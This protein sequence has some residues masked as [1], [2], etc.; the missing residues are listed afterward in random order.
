[1]TDPVT[2][3]K[4]PVRMILR[5]VEYSSAAYYGSLARRQE[6]KRGPKTNLNDADLLME[7]RK[8]MDA[9]PFH[10]TGYKKIHARIAREL[11][12]KGI[13]IGKNRIFRI[14]KENNMLNAKSGG[15]GSSRPHD[16]T[17]ITNAP[18]KMWGTDGKKFFTRQDG[19]CWLFDVIDHFNSE[20][21]GF[22][23]VKIGDRFEASRA[24]QNAVIYR[25]GRLDEGICENLDVRSDRGS[26]YIS[27]YYRQTASRLGI[28]LS[29]TWARSP[30]SNGIAERFHRTIEEQ[31]FKIR[32]FE[33]I[34][35]AE[36]AIREFIE[37]YN[38]EWM[39][40]RLDY[41]S[42]REALNAYYSDKQKS[43]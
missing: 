14:M 30:E 22:N 23:V 12:N 36:I 31:L 21:V 38:R 18:N 9:I 28:M 2:G 16:G 1:M 40:E 43:A 33:T 25:Y 29:Y 39:L 35:E 10:G 37:L 15:T 34:E 6:M 41:L 19:W 3:K 5:V 32:D 8:T 17:L 24:V 7:I 42:P 11:G 20:I 27:K 13:K 4:Y 26:Q